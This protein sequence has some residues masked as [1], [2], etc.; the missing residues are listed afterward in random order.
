MNI[1]EN[2]KRIIDKIEENKFEAYLVGGCV[3]DHILGRV[4]NDYDIATNAL[5]Q[6]IIDIFGEKITI[7]TGLQH[8]TVTVMADKEPFEITTYRTEGTYSDGR[9]PDNVE[10]VKDIKEDLSRRDFTVNAAAYN[11]YSGFED[12][13]GAKEDIEHK[14]IRCVGKPEKRFS[15]DALR[16]LRAV[17][18]SSQ[19]DFE[20]EYETK[21]AVKNMYELLGKISTER[22]TVE[23]LKTLSGISCK[24]VLEEN[25]DVFMYLLPCLK[26]NENIF[27]DNISDVQ[28]VQG[29]IDSI[30]SLS[31]LFM[32][33]ENIDETLENMRLS[34]YIKNS[35][36]ELVLYSRNAVNDSEKC[37]RKIMSE[38]GNEQTERLFAL[39]YENEEYDKRIGI[40]ENIIKENKC[41]SIKD[42][43][44]KGGDIIKILG[45]GGREVGIILKKLFENMIEKDIANDKAV[46][47][48]EAESIISGGMYDE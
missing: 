37:I 42:M 3:R 28:K 27:F 22:K 1:P 23:I 47:L 14:I 16:I 25:A 20:V 2:A 15:E 7:E 18:F 31:A 6:D 43:Q 4:P 10:F 11:P 21:R 34:N 5:P 46:L 24:A 9:H 40:Y 13:F 17:R 12:P 44:V 38:I 8:G 26:M 32:N 35:V 33:M 29:Y 39:M 41:V 30:I 19:L 36:K 45:R 48:E